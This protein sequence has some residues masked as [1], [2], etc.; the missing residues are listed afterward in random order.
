[1]K[2]IYLLLFFFISFCSYCQSIN[3]SSSAAGTTYQIRRNGLGFAA[4]NTQEI[5]TQVLNKANFITFGSRLELVLNYNYPTRNRIEMEPFGNVSFG[6]GMAL[7]TLAPSI[8]I[9]ELTGTTASSQNSGISIP[10]PSYLYNNRV[11]SI[12]LVVNCDV[13]GYFSEEFTRLSGYQ[14]SVSY[15]QINGNFYVWNKAGN[16]G[17]I[18]NKPFKLL[19]TLAAL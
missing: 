1:M 11:V 19:V 18:L 17:L 2:K 7:G 16:S 10:L 9:T 5:N 6:S 15:D 13:D 14:V 3:V 8:S 4:I 12:K